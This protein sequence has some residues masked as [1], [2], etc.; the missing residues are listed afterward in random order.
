MTWTI[1]ELK[2]TVPNRETRTFEEQTSIVV[3]DEQQR[4]VATL[5]GRANLDP[6]M[7]PYL[8]TIEQAREAAQLIVDAANARTEVA[9]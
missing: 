6:V 2:T 7:R 1:E 5:H 8:R 9:A 4:L 3:L